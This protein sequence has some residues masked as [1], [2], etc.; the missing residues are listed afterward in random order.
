MY[1]FLGRL[2]KPIELA[3][4]VLFSRQVSRYAENIIPPTILLHVTRRL[5]ANRINGRTRDDCFTDDENII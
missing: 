1:S 2:L 3:P 5:H 4:S